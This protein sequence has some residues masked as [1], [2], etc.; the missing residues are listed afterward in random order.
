MLRCL[1]VDDDLLV[2][3]TVQYWLRK[4]GF[5]VV[6]ADGADTGL[7]A[8]ERDQFDLMVIDI[9][10]PHMS[11]FE[12]VRLFHE[13]APTIPLIAI[14]GYAFAE[15]HGPAPDFLRMALGFG[16]ARCLRKPFKPSTLLTV[17]EECLIEARGRQ[18]TAR[19]ADPG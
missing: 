19:Q 16:A 18:A 4:Q 11:G 17:M 3:R 1:V 8:L 14:S 15:S 2:L 6:I 10:M 12:S 9:F 5:D 13:R 7:A